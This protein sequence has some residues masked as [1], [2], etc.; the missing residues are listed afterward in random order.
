MSK[1]K[2]I[3]RPQRYDGEKNVQLSVT[4][5]PRYRQALE[6]IAKERQST[7]SEAVELA[8]SK[9]AREMQLEQDFL[10]LY[11][12]I[13]YVRPK[14]EPLERLYNAI[15]PMAGVLHKFKK[16]NHKNAYNEIMKGLNEKPEPLL[17]PLESHVENV[18]AGL[19]NKLYYFNPTHLQEAIKED[20]KEGISSIETNMN[21][22]IVN[23][24][25]EKIFLEKFFELNPMIS[26]DADMKDI[27]EYLD[28]AVYP[29]SDK[30]GDPEKNALSSLCEYYEDIQR[31]SDDKL[32]ELEQSFRKDIANLVKLANSEDD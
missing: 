16:H 28:N 18:L 2:R 15:P 22:R 7:L 25:Y 4:I 10:D 3:G 21:I 26:P 23:E 29:F 30:K 32:N 5:R 12:I 11:Y 6:I 31:P 13:D 19:D 9:L 24:F 8:I 14:S 1:K 17:T 27:K 20:W